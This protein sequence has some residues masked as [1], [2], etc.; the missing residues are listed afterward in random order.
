MTDKYFISDT[1]FGHSNILGYDGRPFDTIEQHDLEVSDRINSTL[2]RGD[3]LFHLGDVAWNQ[4][5]YDTWLYRRRK[6]VRYV[7]LRGNHDYRFEEGQHFDDV[8]WL[9]NEKVF[10]SHYPHLSWPSSFHGSV[11][12]FGHVH[13]MVKGVGRSMDVSANVIDYRPIS[14]EQVLENLKGIEPQ[15]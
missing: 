15:K 11:H 1:H 12:L 14:L 3:I 9:K 8:R 4:E 5:A 2:K 10:L 6:D 7:Q 13:G